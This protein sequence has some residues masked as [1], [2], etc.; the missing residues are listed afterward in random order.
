MRPEAAFR[1][2]GLGFKHIQSGTGDMA[3]IE[4]GQHVLRR[5]VPATRA[6]D[7]ISAAR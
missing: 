2:Q 5:H 4:R 1:G 3:G 6:I 7:H